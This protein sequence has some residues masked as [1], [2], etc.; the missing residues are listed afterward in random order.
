MLTNSK[1]DYIEIKD[2]VK[3]NLFKDIDRSDIDSLDYSTKSPTP[4]HF[5]NAMPVTIEERKP[6]YYSLRFIPYYPIEG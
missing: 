6:D 1:D 3:P 5:N 2:I 4:L